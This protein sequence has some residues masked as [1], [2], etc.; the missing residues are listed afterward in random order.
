MAPPQSIGLFRVLQETLSNV[1]R[2]AKATEVQIRFRQHQRSL[3]LM[4]RDDGQG[5]TRSQIEDS[6]SLGLIGMRE[7]MLHLGGIMTIQGWESLGTAVTFTIP[8]RP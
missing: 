2:H 7:R 6:A 1:A 3:E 5:I 4:I 8:R